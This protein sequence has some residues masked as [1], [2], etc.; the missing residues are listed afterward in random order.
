LREAAS[1]LGAN[2]QRGAVKI[3]FDKLKNPFS[4]NAGTK[5][6]FVEM[7]VENA[8]FSAAS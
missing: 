6:E 1:S 5:W 8:T 2:W 4:F 7:V 3:H